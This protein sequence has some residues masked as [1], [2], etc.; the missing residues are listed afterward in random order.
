MADTRIDK[1]N[2]SLGAA[3]KEAGADAAGADT[4]PIVI[5][6]AAADR[7]LSDEDLDKV[8]GGAAGSYIPPTRPAPTR[9]Q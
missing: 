1:L 5:P 7:E 9:A 3:S 4:V 2:T 6:S 8:S